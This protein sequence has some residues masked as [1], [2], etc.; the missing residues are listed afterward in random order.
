MI[1]YNVDW[2]SVA[3]KRPG[4]AG[5]PG[6]PAYDWAATDGIVQGAARQG[7]RVLLTIVQAPA[8]ANGGGAPRAAPLACE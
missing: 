1:R 6:D 2:S 5:S 4:A 3:R 8:W 7:A